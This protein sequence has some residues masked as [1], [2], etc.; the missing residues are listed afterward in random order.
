MLSH[1]TQC[2]EKG[3]YTRYRLDSHV[4]DLRLFSTKTKAPHHPLQEARFVDNCAPILL[5]ESEM[6]LMLYQFFLASNLFD[7]TVSLGKTEVL[8][9]PAPITNTSAQFTTVNGT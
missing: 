6:Q 2:L 8:Y 1:A 5:I 3:F 7:L 4:F 9:Q